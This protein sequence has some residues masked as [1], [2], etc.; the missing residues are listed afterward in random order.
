MLF[1]PERTYFQ[2]QQVA[3]GMDIGQT[4]YDA[5]WWW[6]CLNRNIFSYFPTFW[7]WRILRW[8]EESVMLSG[9]KGPGRHVW[10][11]KLSNSPVILSFRNI[12][13]GL[14]FF[15]KTNNICCGSSIFFVTWR[16]LSTTQDKHLMRDKYSAMFFFILKVAQVAIDV[17]NCVPDFENLSRI[18]EKG[19]RVASSGR[20]KCS[21]AAPASLLW[22]NLFLWL[23]FNSFFLWS[24]KQFFE[25]LLLAPQAL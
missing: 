20:L 17:D 9:T 8:E 24:D 21:H 18:R 16:T 1:S 19:T 22:H 7:S 6:S 10:S 5:Y 25:V 12:D 14:L 15:C 13:F 4:V 2:L 3:P 23:D 11:L